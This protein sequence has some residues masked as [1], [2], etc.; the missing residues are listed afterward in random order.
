MNKFT[1]LFADKQEIE[2]T[3]EDM[4]KAVLQAFYYAYINKMPLHIKKVTDETDKSYI[5]DVELNF[6]LSNI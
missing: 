4:K 3:A 6:R 2:F 1:I 5:V